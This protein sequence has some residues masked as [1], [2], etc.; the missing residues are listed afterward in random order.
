MVFS[1]YTNFIAIIKRI[2]EKGAQKLFLDKVVFKEREREKRINSKELESS[3]VE[4]SIAFLRSYRFMTAIQPR[5]SRRV[6][7]LVRRAYHTGDVFT[8]EKKI[9]CFT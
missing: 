7:K 2:A 6:R 9:G 5:N 1:F 8:R 3:D 4:M